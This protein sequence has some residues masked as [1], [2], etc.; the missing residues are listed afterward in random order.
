MNERRVVVTGM[1]VVTPVGIGVPRFW[2]ALRDG[3]SGVRRLR[4]IE[5]PEY[6]V[7]IGAEVDLTPDDLKCIKS[8]KMARRLDDFIIY[9]YLAGAE[10]I[11][12]SKLDIE[13]ES[14]RVGVIIASGEGG[15]KTH[16]EMIRRIIDKRLSSVSPFYVTNVIPNT[17]GAFLAQERHIRGPSFAINSAC[18][19]SNHALGT[20]ST[21]IKA[22]LADVMFTG[23]AE[24]VAT[25][26]GMAAF[27]N[28]GAL[29]ARNDDPERASRPFD[30]NRDGFVMGEGAGV[31]CLEELS[32]A[33]KRGAKIYAE[34]S[35]FGFSTDAY[36]L[37]APHPEGEGAARAMQN[38]L[39]MARLGPEDLGFINAHG[40]STPAG[41]RA[42]CRAIQRALGDLGAKIPVHSTK[43]MIGHLIGAAGAVEA[44]A[45][46][47]AFERGLI[48]KNA[49]YQEPDPEIPLNI[50]REN[51]DGRSV[52]HVLSNA[53]GFGGHNACVILSRFEG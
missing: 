4:R 52:K 5:L 53:F 31:L 35:G 6:H 17:P 2:D 29:S 13:A 22:G 32:H 34:L 37:V 36:D 40:T 41:D 8:P 16:Y 25:P 48:H 1:G 43:S 44:I 21:L 11:V 9:G 23:G 47:M 28:I 18:A 51:A 50:L 20:A 39:S 33:Q 42:E 12:D 24:A 46:I 3:K 45:S 19:S 10:A 15:L 27:G 38:A 14:E 26:P 7:Q 30:K 49:N